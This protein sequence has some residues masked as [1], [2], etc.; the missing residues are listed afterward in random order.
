[1]DTENEARA[2]N[3]RLSAD[4]IYEAKVGD[5]DEAGMVN[6]CEPNGGLVSFFVCLRN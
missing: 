5:L 3:S 1:M 2:Q 4:C 6:L